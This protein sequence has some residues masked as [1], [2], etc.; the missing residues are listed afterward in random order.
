MKAIA[1]A[2]LTTAALLMLGHPPAQ[3]APYWPNEPLLSQQTYLQD[4]GMTRAWQQQG[5]LASPVTVAVLDTGYT[6]SPEL[7]G[8][9][10]NGYDFVS[11]PRRAGDGKGRDRSALGVG[12]FAFHSEM[13]AGIIGAS[14]DGVGMAGINPSARILAVRVADQEGMIQVDDLADGLRWAAGLPVEGTTR[15]FF[16]ARIINVSLFA[17]WLPDTGCDPRIAAAVNDV[18]AAGALVVVG[19]GNEDR[20]A[21]R[22]SP[23]GCE[24]VLTVTGTHRGQRPDYANWGSAV[25]LAAPSGSPQ[26]GLAAST[27]LDARGLPT[28]L[29]THRQNGT[30]FAAPQ[31]SGAASLLLGLRPE[32]T[33]A[34]L[35][36]IL[37]W[38]AT[39]WSGRGCDSDPRKSCGA[40]T[41]N[42]AAALDWVNTL[43]SPLPTLPTTDL[44]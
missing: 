44:C 3:A 31:V 18:T 33:P 14:H 22:L 29:H 19:A 39:P 27:A 36:E 16:P 8:R 21:G 4:T 23:A 5:R 11:D 20:D 25:A 12:Q 17:D 42:I 7:R 10:I 26:Q 28:L 35:R 2:A 24:G 40:G 34:E 1:T 9:I 30:S 38:T 32:L 43:A 37:V 15:N 6:R 13:I 41:L